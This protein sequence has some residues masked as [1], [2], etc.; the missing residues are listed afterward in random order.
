MQVDSKHMKESP[1]SLIIRK[2]KSWDITFHTLAKIKKFGDTL[3]AKVGETDLFIHCFV[4]DVDTCS[5]VNKLAC[6]PKL[7]MYILSPTT[8]T[9]SR[10]SC[11]TLCDPTDSS[12]S[13]FSVHRISQARIPE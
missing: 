6:L 3:L 12:P 11:P 4:S 5:M 2:L 9:T 1:T 10:Q 13:G 8:T 7:R